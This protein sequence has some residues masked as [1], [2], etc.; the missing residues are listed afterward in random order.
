MDLVSLGFSHRGPTWTVLLLCEP[1]PN[2]LLSIINETILSRMGCSKWFALVA[3]EDRFRKTGLHYVERLKKSGWNGKVDF[4][5]ILN[6]KI[7]I[8]PKK[9]KKRKRSS[10]SKSC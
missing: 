7:I 5:L 3:D 4:W 2:I 10:N 9:K 8:Q 1:R 6:E